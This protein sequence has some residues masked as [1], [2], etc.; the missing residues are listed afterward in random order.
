MRRPDSVIP[1]Y[2]LSFGMF[3]TVVVI[4]ERGH[5]LDYVL[6]RK[7][8]NDSERREQVSTSFSLFSYYHRIYFIR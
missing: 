3:K 6:P 2:F 1:C 5:L 4:R 8:S 7:F